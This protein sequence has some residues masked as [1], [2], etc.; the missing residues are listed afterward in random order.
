MSSP[1][2]AE[3]YGISNDINNTSKTK[4]WYKEIQRIVVDMRVPAVFIFHANQGISLSS[5]SKQ[6]QSDRSV[7]NVLLHADPKMSMDK[8][9]QQICCK[10]LGKRTPSNDSNCCLDRSPKVNFCRPLGKATPSK[11]WLNEFSK[12][13]VCRLFGSA[14]PAKL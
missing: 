6:L 10:S 11:L 4:R 2:P 13:N 5:M 3:Y 1:Q 9:R 7:R 12:F 14:T 8:P